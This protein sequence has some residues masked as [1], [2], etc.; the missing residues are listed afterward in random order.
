MTITP[1]PEWK[2][3]AKNSPQNPS[4]PFEFY[5]QVPVGAT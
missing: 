5:C 3:A 2:E 1:T 4:Q